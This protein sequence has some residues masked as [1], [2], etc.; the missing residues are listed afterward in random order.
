[1]FAKNYTL[2][3][4]LIAEMA[5][6]CRERGAL[7]RAGLGP[8]CLHGWGGARAM[9]VDPGPCSRGGLTLQWSHWNYPGHQVAFEICSKPGKTAGHASGLKNATH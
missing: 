3:K 1:M 7:F 4:K 8:A 9:K 5:F 6:A 2:C